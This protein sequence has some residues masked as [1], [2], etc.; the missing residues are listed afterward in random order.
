VALGYDHQGFGGIE[1]NDYVGF[2]YKSQGFFVA[3]SKNYLLFTKIQLGLH[4]AVN[5]SLEDLRHVTWPNGF[6]GLDLGINE[7]L[8]F[9]CEYD[10]GL[11]AKELRGTYLNPLKGYLNAG[12]RWAVTKNFRVEFDAKDILENKVS[13]GHQLGWSREFKF[14]YIDQF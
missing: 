2:V 4:G 7:E 5:F 14:V 1:S 11:N 13:G 9:V 12:I 8:A 3:L 6:L 10:L